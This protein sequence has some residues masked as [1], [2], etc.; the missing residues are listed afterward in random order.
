MEQTQK[1]HYSTILPP[2][3]ML[4][5][6]YRLYGPY[7]H[8]HLLLSCYT[9]SLLILSPSTNINIPPILRL[10][11]T[12]STRP[13][14]T[15]PYFNSAPTLTTL[16]TLT[17]TVLTLLLPHSPFSPRGI[18]VVY[19]HP[20]LLPVCHFGCLFCSFASFPYHLSFLST[21]HPTHPLP[22]STSIQ[23]CHQRQCHHY[24]YENC[25]I[26]YYSSTA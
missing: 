23:T 26:L 17:T 18:L 3:T 25:T 6:L 21:Y 4:H 14:M 12:Y 16:T 19:E 5:H 20:S 1:Q 7:Q 9:K 10:L 24:D 8:G 2:N 22:I 13:Y 15:L 11:L